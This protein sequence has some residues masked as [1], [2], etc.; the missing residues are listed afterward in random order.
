MANDDWAVVVGVRLYPDLGDLDGP[1]NDAQAFYDW[2]V[3][4]EGGDV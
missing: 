3:A 4:P 2:L 1:E